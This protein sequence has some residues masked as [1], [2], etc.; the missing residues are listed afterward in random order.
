[1]T[2]GCRC[3]IKEQPLARCCHLW[4]QTRHWVAEEEQQLMC[5]N[6]IVADKRMTHCSSSDDSTSLENEKSKI[7]TKSFESV[8]VQDEKWFNY[9]PISSVSQWTLDTRA[10]TA[11]TATTRTFIYNNK[12]KSHHKYWLKSITIHI[13]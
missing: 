4:T 9:L 13:K 11:N 8:W 1:M 2:V 7:I 10:Q 12:E 6:D 5:L 3:K